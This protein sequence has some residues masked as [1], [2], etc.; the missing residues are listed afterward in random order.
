MHS[1]QSHIVRAENPIRPSLCR[2]HSFLLVCRRIWVLMRL[3]PPDRWMPKERGATRIFIWNDVGKNDAHYASRQLLLRPVSAHTHFRSQIPTHFLLLHKYFKLNYARF[4]LWARVEGENLKWHLLWLALRFGCDEQKS[5]FFYT[6][7]KFF[8][9]RL[10]FRRREKLISILANFKRRTFNIWRWHGT[11]RA[12]QPYYLT[13]N[14][15]KAARINHRQIRSGCK[16]LS[17]RKDGRGGGILWLRGKA[18]SFNDPRRSSA[19]GESCFSQ[20]GKAALGK[21]EKRASVCALI[22]MLWLLL[23]SQPAVSL[24]WLENPVASFSDIATVPLGGAIVF[25]AQCFDLE[26]ADKSG[27]LS[28]HC[29]LRKNGKLDNTT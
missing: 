18:R 9:L 10:E 13:C 15:Q 12:I 28:L 29:R 24:Q 20:S 19:C 8:S 21:R 5:V 6:D 4:A 2:I 11:Q 7:S 25:H 26:R 16:F 1:L 23:L 27:P 17:R 22:C 3:S 14:G